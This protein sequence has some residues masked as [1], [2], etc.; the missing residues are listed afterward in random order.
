MTFK[1]E[2][3]VGGENAVVLRVCGRMDIE[4]VNTLKI[5]KDLGAHIYIDTDVGHAETL[6]QHKGGAKA[7]LATAPSGD[8]VGPPGSGPAARGKPR[9]RSPC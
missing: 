2:R 9:L 6:L 3:L 5:A 4:C 1:I 7:I 8:A